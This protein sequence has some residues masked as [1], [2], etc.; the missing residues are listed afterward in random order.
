MG[1]PG[2]RPP[3]RWNLQGQDRSPELQPTPGDRGAG[4]HAGRQTI[5]KPN[6][7]VQALQEELLKEPLNH[8]DRQA[9]LQHLDRILEP[10]PA[11]VSSEPGSCHPKLEEPEGALKLLKNDEL[12]QKRPPKPGQQEFC[13]NLL[14]QA[15]DL[16][17]NRI[18]HPQT[19]LKTSDLQFTAS[20]VQP[21]VAKVRTNNQFRL[22]EGDESLKAGEG[23]RQRKPSRAVPDDPT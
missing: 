18:P 11:A 12:V 10:S 20:Q 19:K 7:P 13:G 3:A 17:A 14:L 15:R 2:R 8:E 22:L 4:Q 5:H 16:P 1:C 6:P 21:A 9:D 23:N